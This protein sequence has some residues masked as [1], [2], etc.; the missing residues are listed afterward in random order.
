MSSWHSYPSIFNLGHRAVRE[1]L[2]YPHIVEEKVDGS[3]FSFGWFPVQ[4][5]VGAFLQDVPGVYELRVRSKGCVM[6]PDAPERMFTKAVASV[7]ERQ[8]L[9]PVGWTYRC[10]YLVKPQHNS[11]AYDRVPT[12]YLIGF[13]VST[14]DNE[15]LS[16]EDK[17]VEFSRIGLECVPVLMEDNFG[18]RTSLDGLRKIIDTRVSVLGGQLI[19]GVVIKPLVELYGVDKKTLMGKFVSERFKEVHRREWSKSNPSNGDIIDQLVSMYKAEGRWLKSAQHLREAGELE[20]SPRDISKLIN[21]VRKDTGKEEK[22]EIQ[23]KL[24][25]WAWPRIERGIVQGLPEWWKNELLRKQ[26]ENEDMPKLQN[27]ESDN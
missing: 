6:N 9:L 15:W 20:F 1:L 17:V 7:K 26:F 5:P 19:E 2:N 8:H 11:L 18:N 27:S 14:G 16:P 13:D 12:G 22:E 10:E 4:E 3:Q 25:K 23:R 21:E 24:W